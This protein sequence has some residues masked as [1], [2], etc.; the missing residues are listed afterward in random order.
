MKQQE[1]VI[2]DTTKTMLVLTRG[3]AK[4]V[5]KRIDNLK[6]KEAYKVAMLACIDVLSTGYKNISLIKLKILGI[7]EDVNHLYPTMFLNPKRLEIA[8]Y[9]LACDQVLEIVNS[10]EA[11]FIYGVNIS[12]TTD[13]YN[14]E[15]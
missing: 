12:D 4:F 11:R 7:R 6:A 10:L 14:D 2:L 13:A 5:Y 15:F 1:E 3:T 8:S 9:S